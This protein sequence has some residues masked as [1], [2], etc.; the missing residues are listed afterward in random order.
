MGMA[1]K[2]ENSEE[3]TKD[4]NSGLDPKKMGKKYDVT[5]AT[6][7]RHAARLGLSTKRQKN[8]T[9]RS[10]SILKDGSWVSDARG[11]ARWEEA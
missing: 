9:D 11:I 8:Y 6:I 2:I 5:T 1:S 4:W 10:P 3:F 7:Y